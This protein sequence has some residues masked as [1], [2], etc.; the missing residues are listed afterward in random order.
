MCSLFD[1]HRVCSSFL[2][3]FR[4]IPVFISACTYIRTLFAAASEVSVLYLSFS[5]KQASDTSSRLLSPFAQ[6]HVHISICVVVAWIESEQ[7]YKLCCIFLTPLPFAYGCAMQTASIQSRNHCTPID[8]MVLACSGACLNDDIHAVQ[9]A[10]FICIDP[11]A[12]QYV[13]TYI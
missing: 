6:V 3:L 9:S 7:G 11:A 12:E 4:P 10:V 8:S 5:L 2:A 13:Y 1:F